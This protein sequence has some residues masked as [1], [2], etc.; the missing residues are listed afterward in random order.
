MIIKIKLKNIKKLNYMILEIV[1]K[2]ESDHN[3]IIL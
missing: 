3:K 1:N 2:T